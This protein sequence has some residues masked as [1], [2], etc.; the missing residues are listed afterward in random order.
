M[1]YS[2]SEKAEIIR[3]VG[4]SA[5]PVKRTLEK[6][7]IRAAFYLYGRLSLCKSILKKIRFGS[8][9]TSIRRHP[10]VTGRDRRGGL[11]ADALDPGNALTCLALDV[12]AAID[13]MKLEHVL[14]DVDAESLDVHC[15]SPY[16]CRLSTCGREGEP[17]IPLA[18][19]ISIKAA[20]P[21]PWT[22]ARLGRI[23]SGTGSPTW[24]E[25]RSSNSR[26]TSRRFRR[27]N[28][29]WQQ[30][31]PGK[32]ESVARRPSYLHWTMAAWS[33]SCRPASLRRW[34]DL[35]VTGLAKFLPYGDGFSAK[36]DTSRRRDL[37][38]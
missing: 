28:S 10:M 6:L 1:R 21:K 5:L 34:A 20:G 35:T 30:P 17:S 16:C 8:L 31:A 27:A 2:V 36:F 3:L 12:A 33:P 29:P 15:S 25:S 38:H 24:C 26:S 9:Q 13:P 22:I 7:G 18:G 37:L 14:G 32:G 19:A 23:A 4:Q 11:R